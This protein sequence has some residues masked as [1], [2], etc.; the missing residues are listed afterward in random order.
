MAGRAKPE[1]RVD[2]RDTMFA[3]MA[4]AAGTPQHREYYSRHPELRETD[5]RIR[6]LPGLLEPGGSYY[7]RE[8]AEEAGEFFRL[9][10]EIE[11]EDSLVR[12]WAGRLQAAESPTS[13]LKELLIAE[14][15]VAAG[16]AALDERY[17]YTHKGRFPE[18]SGREI[19]LDHPS[20][21]VF[22]VEMDFD[23]MQ[24]APQAET[25]RESAQQYYRAARLSLLLEKVLRATGHA[26]KAH[27]DAHYDLILPP[28]AV[29][30]GLGELGR[31]N[32]LI[33]GRYGSRVRIGAVSTDF[34][35]EHDAPVSLGADA[36]CEVCRKCAENCP[37]RSLSLLEKEVVRGVRKWPTRVETC[38]GYWRS[39]GTDCG[40]CMACCPFSH[41][42][43]AFHNLV[44]WM[45][46]RFRFLRR[47][48]VFCENLCYGR[49]WRPR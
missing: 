5:D 6:R 45:I 21:I 46:R 1:D 43:N 11:V 2:E 17:V 32:I 24:R 27:Y 16:C 30:A 25:I 14:G 19:G 49:T 9:I 38:Y 35:V 13:C 18:E 12:A 28:L 26:A 40:V 29:L 22:L 8:I 31:N 41:R 36:L 7:D 47:P 33:A 34:Q 37:S 3:R 15:A 4:L 44:R 42:N 23:E 48:A 10:G 39:V 20:V